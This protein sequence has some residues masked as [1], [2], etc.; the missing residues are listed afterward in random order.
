MTISCF[1]NHFCRLAD[2][3][4][5]AGQVAPDPPTNSGSSVIIAF[6]NGSTASVG[7]D[8]TTSSLCGSSMPFGPTNTTFTK[9]VGYTVYFHN[10]SGIAGIKPS[11]YVNS[12]VYDDVETPT[13]VSVASGVSNATFML[14]FPA[15][16]EVVG[17]WGRECTCGS[18]KLVFEL[19]PLVALGE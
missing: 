11:T 15:T 3:V 2:N 6:V 12:A 14:D 5:I 19:N 17:F 13:N 7:C 9:W 8:N 16:D 4:C 10:G 1:L 18:Y